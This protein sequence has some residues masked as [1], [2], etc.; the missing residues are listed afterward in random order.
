MKQKG[1]ESKQPRS[2]LKQ[3]P[4]ICLMKYMKRLS[5]ACTLQSSDLNLELPEHKRGA[6]PI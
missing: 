3:H 2:S 5:Q 1:H 6:L 4:G